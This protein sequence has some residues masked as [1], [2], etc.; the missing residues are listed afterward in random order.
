MATSTGDPPGIEPYIEV[1]VALH[2]YTSTESTCLSFRRGDFIYVHG[3]DPSGWWDGTI[4]GTR[5]WFPSNYVQPAPMIPTE[6][7]NTF[8]SRPSST[9]SDGNKK[10]ATQRKLDELQDM[11]EL[12]LTEVGPDEKEAGGGDKQK[13]TGGVTIRERTS[14]VNA[15]SAEIPLPKFWGKKTTPQG[16]VYYYNTQTN[17]TTYSLEEV[18][19]SEKTTRRSTLIFMDARQQAASATSP[20]TPA[21]I[22][23]EPQHSNT[24]LPP[25]RTSSWRL[26]PSLIPNSAKVTWDILINNVLH[27]IS[28]LNRAADEG[29]RGL[30]LEQTNIILR[31]IRDMMVASGTIASSGVV[32]GAPAQLKAQHHPIML[33]LSKL[34]I[35]AKVA[36]GLWPPPDAIASMKYEASQ[37]LLGVRHFVSAG[38][39]LNIELRE[40]K[41]DTA[42]DF[43]ALGSDLSSGEFVSRLD[44]GA[45][46]VIKG[47]ARLVAVIT[48]DRRASGVLIEHARTTVTEIG[49]LMSLVEDLKV[50][51][52]SQMNDN[53]SQLIVDF[54]KAK[55][56]AYDIVNDMI[57]FTRTAMDAF[58]PPK[59]L[60]KLL[61]CTSAVLRIIDDLVMATKLL[62][63]SRD[64]IEQQ[65]LLTEAED[66]QE[67]PKRESDLLM[68]QRRAMSLNLL[69]SANPGPGDRR[70]SLAGGP[71]SAG[72]MSDGS[73]DMEKRSS[74]GQTLSSPYGASSA[75]A[76]S[77]KFQSH[78]NL[79]ASP[80]ISHRRPSQNPIPTPN[81]FDEYNRLPMRHPGSPSTLAEE[82]A[83]LSGGSRVPG[84]R[85]SQGS[86]AQKRISDHS[87]TRVSGNDAWQDDFGSPSFETPVPPK[88]NAD[89]LAKFFGERPKEDSFKSDR[90]L[91][92]LDTDYTPDSISFNKEGAVNG[93]TLD[94]LIERLTLHDQPAG[95]VASS[96]S[97]N[98]FAD[99]V[100]TSAFLM[101]FRCFATPADF[102]ER[103]VAR[104]LVGP[105][106]N[107]NSDDLKIWQEKK[108]TPI[109]LRVYN[110]WKL[111]LE[112]YW[113]EDDDSPVLERMLAFAKGPITEHQPAIANRLVQ[114]VHAKYMTLQTGQRGAT[115]SK[116]PR[117]VNND[118]PPAAIIPRVPSKKLTLLDIDPLEIGRQLTILQSRM[119]NAIHPIELINLEWSKKNSRA[120]NVRAMTDLSNKITC[121]VVDT[122]LSEG[123]PKKRAV[124]LKHFIKVGDRALSLRNYDLAMGVVSAL[125][126]SS[127]SRL[128]KTWALLTNKTN[129]TLANLHFIT[130]NSRNYA[131]YRTE[132]RNLNPPCIPFL[133]LYLTDLTFTADGNP[134]IRNERLIN[135]DKFVKTHRIITEIQRFQMPY[136]LFE[137]AE[138]ADWLFTGIKTSSQKDA[139]SLYD[140]SLILEPRGNKEPDETVAIKEL[141]DKLRLLEEAGLL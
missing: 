80:I 125:N 44:E 38:Q 76:N 106:P 51:D 37:V 4:R 86:E 72:V 26:G 134:D 35:T 27:S 85:Q 82:A 75:M 62:I 113:I 133:G 108:Q 115:T 19:K 57:T 81:G 78:P 24:G 68:L 10:S 64:F 61:D 114:L 52:L 73:N 29:K 131:N 33:A 97:I 74:G 69:N 130:D 2:D 98:V 16:Q 110:T 55:E 89:K 65:S 59:A 95:G 79:T 123:D 127:I 8:N 42:F 135:F 139:Q 45:D 118:E 25:R 17:Q 15:M 92:F 84:T 5:G 12:M 66:L 47:I 70:P 13:Q 128:S 58:A 43:E 39:E 117:K 141:E 104:Y 102:V 54:T 31:A 140:L 88:R 126:S 100:F 94:A 56:A 111:W 121:W 11:L 71:E 34:V 3:K 46:R 40:P 30:F 112:N 129:D 109:R 67:N 22:A 63:D 1:V 101:M 99:P 20:A 120:V 60:T 137:V 124:I 87:G 107:I 91:W 96:A 83:R 32:S 6:A 103:M 48:M 41:G 90:R 50:T 9:S 36:S 105:P 21:T 116:P 93:G 14:S 132:L 53:L 122:I 138:L 28:D 77:A 23:E 7:S 18:L 49:Q 136:A 119:F